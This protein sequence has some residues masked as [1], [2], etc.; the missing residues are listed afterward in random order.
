MKICL[1][2]TNPIKGDIDKNIANHKQFIALAIAQGADMIVFPELSLTG[3]EPTLA[4]D[5]A[6]TQ[7]DERL[8]DFQTISED[9]TITIGVGLPTQGNLGI[10][11]SMVL[12][13]PGQPRQ[14]YSKQ[15][16]HADEFPYFVNG[17]QQIVVTVGEK[18]VAPAICYESLQPE[19]AACACEKGANVYMASVAKSANGVGKA[20]RHYPEIAK[21]YS[22]PVLMANCL[23]PCDDFVS[24]G[25]SAIWNQEG[26]LVVRLNETAEG[27]LLY[28]TDNNDC[29]A[30]YI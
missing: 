19:H 16:L 28:N 12:F 11:I 20:F 5:L 17:Q 2:Q 1:A 8:A 29:T 22:M 23:G 26:L 13:Q 9:H 6:S 15:L 10:L 27:I 3:Y 7:E 4:K 14:T 24:V 18:T 21:Q 25:Q 30:L